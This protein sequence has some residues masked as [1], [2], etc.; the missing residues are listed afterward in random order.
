[1]IAPAARAY[2]VVF[3]T[4]SRAR[5]GAFTFRLWIND[6]TPPVVKLLTKTVSRG[7]LLKLSVVDSGSG[8]DPGSLVARVDGKKAAMVY[9]AGTVT[10][11]LDGLFLTSG[12]HTVQLTAS[13]WQETKNMESFGNVLPTTRNFSAS[14]IVR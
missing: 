9:T 5:A 12:R 6:T 11:R 3:D 14:F 8:V 2:D 13:D 7:G 4:P 10:V 1:V